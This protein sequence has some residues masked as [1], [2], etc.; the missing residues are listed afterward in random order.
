MNMKQHHFKTPNDSPVANFIVAMSAMATLVDTLPKC[1]NHAF[2]T[3]RKEYRKWLDNTLR[4]CNLMTRK[5]E[6]S[7]VDC[8]DREA[9]D[10][11]VM[12]M[13]HFQKLLGMVAR[14]DARD[15]VMISEQVKE[16]IETE[17]EIDVDQSVFS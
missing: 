16:F 14:V 11:M 10:Q 8:G 15:M 6:K 2:F 12:H 13:H 1:K 7:V 9:D 17:Y 3:D 5:I 4:F